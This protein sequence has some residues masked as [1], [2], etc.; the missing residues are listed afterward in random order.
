MN[1]ADL[2]FQTL[3]PEILSP[4]DYTD[5]EAIKQ[6]VKVIRRE[7]ALLQSLD[8]DNPVEDLTDLLVSAPKILKEFYWDLNQM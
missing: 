8:K 3:T 6:K 7:I 1:K 5:W 2:F 4:R